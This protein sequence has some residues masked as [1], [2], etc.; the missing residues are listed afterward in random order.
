MIYTGIL[1]L[2][3][4]LYLIL[5]IESLLLKILI[6]DLFAT[7]L[8]WLFSFIVKNQSLYDPYWSV[9]PPLI[10]FLIIHETDEYTYSMFLILIPML[11]WAIRLTYN[12]AKLWTDFKHQD[13][14]YENIKNKAPK[15]YILTSLFAIMIFPTLI[16]F[17]QHIGIV[18]LSEANYQISYLGYVGSFVIILAAVIQFISDTQMQFF[19]KNNQDKHKLIDIGLW[20]YSRHPNYLGEIMVWWGLYLFYLDGIGFDYLIIAPLAMTI[21][22]LF[23]SI[24]MLEKKILKTRPHYKTYQENTSMLIPLTKSFKKIVKVEEGKI[25]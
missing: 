18:K 14:R 20:K 12:W 25:E 10:I 1:A 2:S 17:V 3:Y 22:F 23:V 16:V 13:W 11:I 8:V 19:K 5:P 7:V 24:P 21:M 15:L 9:I 4:G 6:I